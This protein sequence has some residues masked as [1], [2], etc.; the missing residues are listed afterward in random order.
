MKNIFQ[1]SFLEKNAMK[2]L[3]IQL[4]M[5]INIFLKK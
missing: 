3:K 4:M 2:I 1:I 5:K